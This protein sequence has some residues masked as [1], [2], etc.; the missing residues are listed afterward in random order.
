VFVYT[1]KLEFCKTKNYM[2]ASKED[3]CDTKYIVSNA[4]NISIY[5][6]SRNCLCIANT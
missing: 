6:I 4:C 1:Y 3:K 5:E 2:Y